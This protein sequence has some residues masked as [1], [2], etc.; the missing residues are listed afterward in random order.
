MKYVILVATLLFAGC[1]GSPVK[2]NPMDP[3]EKNPKLWWQADTSNMKDEDNPWN[4]FVPMPKKVEEPKL[5]PSN[6]KHKNK[7]KPSGSMKKINRVY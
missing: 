5:F 6:W 7:N 3:T 4:K 2:Q 1:V